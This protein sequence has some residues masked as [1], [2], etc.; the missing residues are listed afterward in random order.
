MTYVFAFAVN[1]VKDRLVSRLGESRL[2]PR[3]LV[4]FVSVTETLGTEVEG[5]AEGLVDACEG[6]VAGH[7]DLGIES[8]ISSTR[9]SRVGNPT[10]VEEVESDYG[11]RIPVQMLLSMPV[12]AWRRK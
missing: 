5:I 6:V 8:V 10:N 1:T 12:G 11:D 2:L 4:T 3:L 7:E 9:R